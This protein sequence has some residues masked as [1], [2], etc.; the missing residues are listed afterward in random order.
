MGGASSLASCA[1][2]SPFSG[3]GRESDSGREEK[4]EFSSAIC[5]CERAGLGVRLLRARLG[6][7]LLTGSY[8]QLINININKYF[9]DIT[10]WI[11]SGPATNGQ[12]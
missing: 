12:I 10:G 11:H 4:V 8:H 1:G 2:S 5:V 7:S 3:T 6:V 9:T